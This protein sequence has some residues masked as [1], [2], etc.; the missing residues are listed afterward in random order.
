MKLQH[1]LGLVWLILVISACG[2]GGEAKTSE[3]QTKAAT[4][5]R[6]TARTPEPAP[7]PELTSVSESEPEPEII[8]SRD[9]DFTGVFS[10]SLENYQVELLP[11]TARLQS[12]RKNVLVSIGISNAQIEE[13]KGTFEDEDNFYTVAQDNMFYMSELEEKA[14]AQGI[15]VVNAN[16]RYLGF[17]GI[18]NSVK[19]L[20][21]LEK[22]SLRGVY[23]TF[24]AFNTTRGARQVADIVDADLEKL[25][26][27]VNEDVYPAIL[28]E[29][30]VL[31][32]LPT[33]LAAQDSITDADFWQFLED[34]GEA[35]RTLGG[36]NLW[37]HPQ[38][39]FYDQWGKE[40]HPLSMILE[41][42]ADKLGYR[43]ISGQGDSH[44]SQSA[45]FV[46][47]QLSPKVSD[48]MREFL[49]IFLLSYTLGYW[50]EG[51]LMVAPTEI[52]RHI[53]LWERFAQKDPDFVASEYAT[54]EAADLVSYLIDEG[55][56]YD[57][58][59]AEEDSTLQV[60]FINGFEYL[61]QEAPETTS[62]RKIAE[63]YRL[64]EANQFKK[65]DTVAHYLK[66]YW[67]ERRALRN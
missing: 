27:Y 16:E 58:Y 41:R 31:W 39:M 47:A 42:E 50:E 6:D 3:A 37:Y 24:I 45:D 38:Y 17:L 11:D 25:A 30:T 55:V 63:Y 65:T 43:F 23:W 20:Y 8:P 34:Y 48:T 53:V 18:N 21:D 40:R 44:F 29:D 15:K 5:A 54:I 26:H 36:E 9:P 60:S 22:D 12:I 57:P 52:A 59:F 46:R 1:R 35:A 4:A 66:V 32:N 62:G 49:D 64:L 19:Q 14:K 33:R 28:L 2:S 10:D 13:L 67:E 56:S 7:R 61:I 51:S